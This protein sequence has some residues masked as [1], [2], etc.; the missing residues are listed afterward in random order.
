LAAKLDYC[1]TTKFMV[2]FPK[3]F[4][5]AAKVHRFVFQSFVGS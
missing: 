3:V 2:L 5:G 1:G 4:F